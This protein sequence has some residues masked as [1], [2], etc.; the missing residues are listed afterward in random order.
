MSARVSSEAVL[1]ARSAVA[2]SVSDLG[3]GDLLIVACSGGPDSLALAGAL[4]AVAAPASLR[5]L[6]VAVDHG[7]QDGSAGV[8]V[9]AASTCRRLGI[10]EAV[11]VAVQVGTEGGP[12]AAARTARYAA[13]ESVA[14]ERDASAVLLGH[15][16]D[17]Q[18]ETVLLR[19]ARGSGA[20]SLS[21][22]RTRSGPWRRPF[23][24]L[25][26]AQ[27]HTA[28]RDLLEPLGVEPWTDPHNADRTFAR[29]RIRA[30]LED[31]T[32]AVGPGAVLGLSR[33]A[34]LLRDDADALEAWSQR[35]ADRVVVIEGGE[36]SVDCAALTDLPRAI[37]T[38]VIRGMCLAAGSPPDQLTIEHVERVEAF[39]TDW[40]GQGAASL[41][42]GVEATRAYGRLC[43]RS[44][45]RP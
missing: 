19:L 2:A 38:R 3:A 40:R 44:S 15:T 30:V 43:L 27:V 1:A 42:G 35:E 11:V 12:E 29:V 13:L 7:L 5:T 10:D 23:L 39:V 26:R 17:D 24:G 18:A 16:R 25:S 4:A 8:S 28:A 21:A 31:L 34:E 6:A 14:V 41:P 22:M 9:A 32:A 45:T 33:S 37:R 20:R 36:R